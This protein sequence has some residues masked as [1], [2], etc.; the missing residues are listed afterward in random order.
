MAGARPHRRRRSS[1]TA[2]RC[3]AA[4]RDQRAITAAR[5][6]LLRWRGV[7]FAMR[8]RPPSGAIF[9][10]CR[11]DTSRV[12]P[13][14]ALTARMGVRTWRGSRREAIRPRASGSSIRTNRRPSAPRSSGKVLPPMR[15]IGRG[16]RIL[17]ACPA[18]RPAAASSVSR[19]MLSASARAR[20]ARRKSSSVTKG[21]PSGVIEC[22]RCR[23]GTRTRQ[24]HR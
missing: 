18:A 7:I 10:R 12:R 2:G 17:L 14:P 13:R 4:F 11:S 23:R 22:L 19:E 6:C 21:G 16:A 9:R 20:R 1:E 8:A 15:L 5:A 3:H 24:N